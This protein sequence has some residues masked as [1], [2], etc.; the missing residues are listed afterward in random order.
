M[1]TNGK[2]SQQP[3]KYTKANSIVDPSQDAYSLSK[4]EYYT[5]YAF[6]VTYSMCGSQSEKKRSLIDYGWKDKNFTTS[7]AKAALEKVFKL[8]GNADFCFTAQN[9][10]AIRFKERDLPDGILQNLDTE[11]AVI[12]KTSGGNKYLKLFY[13]VR[14]GFAHGNFSLRYNSLSEKMVVIQDQ[15]G[16]NVTARIVI[17]L[18]TLLQMVH[19]IDKKHLIVNTVSNITGKEVA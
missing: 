4:D 7:G 16:Y 13:R 19:A 14:D 2:K 6:F 9:D 15:D 10:L 12:A 5:L 3:Y 18:D 11:R 1:S 17:K 8:D